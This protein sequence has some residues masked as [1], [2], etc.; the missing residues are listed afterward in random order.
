MDSADSQ[1]IL[2]LCVCAHLCMCVQRIAGLRLNSSSATGH[3]SVDPVFHT[4]LL[5]LCQNMPRALARLVGLFF[6]NKVAK[7]TGLVF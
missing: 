3:V 1:W 4:S 2:P 7:A 5:A 6:V